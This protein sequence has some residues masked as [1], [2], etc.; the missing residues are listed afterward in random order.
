MEYKTSR[1]AKYNKLIN[2]WWC[3]EEEDF[4]THRSFLVVCCYPTTLLKTAK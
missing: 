1:G 3:G 2:K 4:P